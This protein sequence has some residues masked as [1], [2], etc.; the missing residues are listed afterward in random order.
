LIAT[1]MKALWQILRVGLG[2]SVLCATSFADTRA[3]TRPAAQA[4]PRTSGHK[5]L[6]PQ[7][8]A[9]QADA[10]RN[11]VG[12]WLER[13]QGL[14]Q[15]QC[16][17]CHG[18]MDS[19]KRSVASFPRLSADGKTLVNLEDQILRC[20]QRG[21]ALAPLP[22]TAALE[23]DSVLSLSAALHQVAKGERIQVAP[24]ATA[25]PEHA[26][27]WQARLSSGER[28]YQT[29]IGRMNLA[30]MHCHDGKVGAQMR[31]DTISPAHPTGFPIYR[32]AW[33]TLGST[34]RRLRACYSGVQAPIPSA[35]SADLRDLEL[36]LKVRANGMLLDGPSIRR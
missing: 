21:A 29:R 36:F 17:S 5:Y 26:A 2:L 24:S 27:Q 18:A 23:S 8:Q 32:M 4:D 20:Q 7:L 6:S 31:A 25:S 28:L 14:W 1:G 22:G 12:L 34:D 33:Q 35:G 19:V 9:L 16:T 15:A 13:G 11:P 3:D 10:Q 30:C